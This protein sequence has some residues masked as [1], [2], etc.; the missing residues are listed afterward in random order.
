MAKAGTTNLLPQ[1]Q[2]SVQRPL[3]IQ[4]LD[5]PGL[6]SAS[7]WCGGGREQAQH[8]QSLTLDGAH[9]ARLL[10]VLL[11]VPRVHEGLAAFQ[12]APLFRAVHVVG[13]GHAQSDGTC[14]SMSVLPS[15]PIAPAS[16]CNWEFPKPL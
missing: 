3:C 1:Q 11:P 6:G 15:D 12:E 9:H 13:Q 14:V 5:V 8:F 2:F 4:E 7:V 16:P 10:V